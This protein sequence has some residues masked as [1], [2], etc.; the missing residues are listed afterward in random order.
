MINKITGL[1]KNIF[2]FIAEFARNLDYNGK[3][4]LF[5]SSCYRLLLPLKKKMP[6]AGQFSLNDLDFRYIRIKSTYE[7]D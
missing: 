3:S 4:R 6:M 5:M 1:I 7:N 2:S